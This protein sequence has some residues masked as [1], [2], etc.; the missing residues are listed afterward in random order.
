M[1]TARNDY[2]LLGWYTDKTDGTR[3]SMDVHEYS[4]IWR[5]WPKTASETDKA[6]FVHDCRDLIQ[7]V[8]AINAESGGDLDRL[9]PLA[10][11][12]RNLVHE[13]PERIPKDGF[14]DI[15]K[16]EYASSLPAAQIEGKL[17]SELNRRGLIDLF[18]SDGDE[19][20]R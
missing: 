10:D 13:I 5:F 11:E 2:R 16:L 19:P 8:R 9:S 14:P 3:Q 20:C 6:N 4:W 18:N 17:L 1:R 12:A 7:R 15:N